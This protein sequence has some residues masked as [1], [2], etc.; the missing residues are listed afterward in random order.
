MNLYDIFLTN[1]A[2]KHQ[3]MLNADTGGS[4]LMGLMQ[5]S[6]DAVAEIAKK[7]EEDAKLKQQQEAVFKQEKDLDNSTA[8]KMN[9]TITIDKTGRTVTYKPY[10]GMTVIPSGFEVSGYSSTGKPTLKK[11]IPGIENLDYEQQIQ[12]RA[13]ARRVAGVRGAEN[14][15][16]TIVAGMS[17]GLNIDQIEDSIRYSGQ[18]KEFTGPVRNAAQSILAN[19]PLNIKESAMDAIDDVLSQGNS[20]EVKNLLKK[21]SRD[22]AG[23]EQAKTIMGKERTVEF[24]GEIQDDFDILEANGIN[25]NIFTGTFEDMNKNIGRVAN[26]ELR[27]IA[28]KI[29]TAIM[30]YRKSMTGVQ[31]SAAESREYYNMFPSIGKT[32]NFNKANIDALK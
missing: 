25:T 3:N 11:Q 32:S 9:K 18:S 26:P 2:R 19:T 4:M 28:T 10:E 27:K 22:T 17:E 8:G 23:T 13:L 31:F 6:I 16:P 7:K 15:L 5:G 24:L 1:A 30:N 21:V 14:L 20:E 12:A 29:Q